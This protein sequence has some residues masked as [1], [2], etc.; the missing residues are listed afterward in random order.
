MV[1]HLC[2]KLISLVRGNKIDVF[3]FVHKSAVIFV[4]LQCCKKVALM[5]FKS[6][7]NLMSEIELLKHP[8]TYSIP[9]PCITN[10]L[11]AT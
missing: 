10:L 11:L 3:A 2:Q 4:L 5:H 1:M 8:K 9:L 7:V 6:S